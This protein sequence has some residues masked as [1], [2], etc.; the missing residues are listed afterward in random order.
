M[1]VFILGANGFIGSHLV[2]KILETTDWPIVAFDLYGEYLEEIGR[3]AKQGR[4]SFKKGDIFK[5]D[6]W[7]EEQSSQNYLKNK[8]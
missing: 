4:F 1:K 6:L 7:I 8:Q 5:E 2:E 3:C